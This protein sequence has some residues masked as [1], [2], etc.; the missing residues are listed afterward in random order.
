M[1]IELYKD[2]P[3]VKQAM[4]L[5]TAAM[6][7][8]GFIPG[9]ECGCKIYANNKDGLYMIGIHSRIYGCKTF[10]GHVSVVVVDR[11]PR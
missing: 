7:E 4:A 3:I 1:A 10:P 9:D 6:T 2:D 8:V 11:K 5:H